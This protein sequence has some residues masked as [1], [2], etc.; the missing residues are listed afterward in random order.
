[1]DSFEFTWILLEFFGFFWSMYFEFFLDSFV[2]AGC[3]YMLS[4][5]VVPAGCLC[6]LFVQLNPL[7]PLES[8]RVV[9]WS[10]WDSCSPELLSSSLGILGA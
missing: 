3:L 1:M 8:F 9:A 4:L 7:N 5:Q 2:S 6:R 10:A